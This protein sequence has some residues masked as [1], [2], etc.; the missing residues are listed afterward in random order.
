[1]RAP[2]LHAIAIAALL[3]AATTPPAHARSAAARDTTLG[4]FLGTL[5]DSTDD[6]FGMSAAPVDTAGLDT[7]IMDMARAPGRLAFTGLPTFAFNRVDG[8]TPGAVLG[9]GDSRFDQPAPGWGRLRGS[10]A[11][12]SGP[13]RVLGGVRYENH[14]WL[15]RQRFDL[16]LWAGRK[17]ASM[18]L[19]TEMDLLG[20]LRALLSGSDRAQ[21]LRNDGFEGSLAH[22]HGSWAARAGWRDVLQSPLATT[23]TWNLARNPLEVPGNLPAARG[24]LREANYFGALQ[25]P[26]VPLRT[27]V[28]FRSSSRRFGSDFEY[29]RTRAAAGLDLSLGRRASLVP[30]IAY[31]HLTG[32]AVPQA[33]FYMGADA[34]MRSLPRDARAGTGL[35]IAKL[36]LI[37]AHDLLAVLH[38]PHPAMLPMRGGLFMATSATWGPDPNTGVVTR[39]IDLPDRRDFVSE[40]GVSLLYDSVF[41]GPAS[42]LRIS[43]A[44]PIGPTDHAGR[45]S[46]SL[47]RALDLLSPE[48]E[49]E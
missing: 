28:D 19:D 22:R 11:R 39:G 7:V 14:L 25:W 15:A 6:Y 35:V 1:M 32:D 34:T 21:Y 30:Q 24:R 10:L 44:W 13:R 2:L 9:L 12:A 40:A 48:P 17:T 26:R 42:F 38:I 31:G 5:S 33:S 8:S 47:S 45:W 3:A 46:V 36:D 23:A 37:G 18:D 49:P 41:L 16:G 29:R 4:R 27:E 43:Y 20:T